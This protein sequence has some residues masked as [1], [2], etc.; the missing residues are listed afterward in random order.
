MPLNR[1]YL[2]PI[3]CLAM[4]SGA[5]AQG[6]VA[7]QQPVVGQVSV[8]TVVS[9]PDR[10]RL[11]LGG[12]SAAGAGR[13]EYGPLPSGTATGRFSRDTA[14]DVGVFIHDFEAM[15][16]ALLARPVRRAQRQPRIQSPRAAAAWRH[17][18]GQRGG[19]ASSN[20]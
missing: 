14:L 15:D 1:T 13:R 3:V 8:D 7:V 11:F 5:L 18:Q 16:E 12:V 20:R 10:G 2:L 6:Q 17:L 9:V 19:R 4:T